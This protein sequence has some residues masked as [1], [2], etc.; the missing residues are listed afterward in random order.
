M[1]KA[2]ASPP[3]LLQR[4][5]E[6]I[7]RYRKRGV[8]EVNN[9]IPV[10]GIVEEKPLTIQEMVQKYIREELSAAAVQDGEGSFDEEDDFELDDD[11]GDLPL[12]H[13]QV[14][15][16]SDDELAEEAQQYGVE[17]TN[18]EA[19]QESESK[20]ASP[21]GSKTPKTSREVS[22]VSDSSKSVPTDDGEDPQ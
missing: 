22:D 14:I 13:H 3:S 8:P 2:S 5:G 19:P 16:M 15:A 10:E 20:G 17:L 7:G 9:G 18:G 4:A 21:K 12:T 1:G 6:L 11:E